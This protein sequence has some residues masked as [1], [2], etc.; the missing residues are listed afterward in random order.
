MR[1]RR[2]K[3]NNYEFCNINKLTKSR[4]TRLTGHV[5]NILVKR[6]QGRRRFVRPQ[7]IC[8]VNIK[9]I[10]QA[11]GWKNVD[12]IYLAQDRDQR[13]ALVNTAI[14]FCFYTNWKVLEMSDY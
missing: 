1:G 5:G 10:P 14:N 4:Q 3:L 11:I 7:Q 13:R 2:R 12:W 6:H 8:E 9:T